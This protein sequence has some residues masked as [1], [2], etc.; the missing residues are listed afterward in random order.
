MVLKKKKKVNFF[1]GSKECIS[2]LPDTEQV[3][4]VSH[5]CRRKQ[6]AGLHQDNFRRFLLKGSFLK[7]CCR[8][9]KYWRLATV[10]PSTIPQSEAVARLSGSWSPRT[11]RAFGSFI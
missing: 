4:Y 10:G 2:P 11:F 1:V 3:G 9:T 5:G 6:M 8:Q 7:V